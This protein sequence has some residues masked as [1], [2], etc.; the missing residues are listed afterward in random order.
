M[1]AI[2]DHVSSIQSVQDENYLVGV[3]LKG[4]T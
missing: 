1:R 2:C 3:P 4:N